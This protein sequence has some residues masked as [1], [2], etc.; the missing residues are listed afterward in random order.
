MRISYVAVVAVAL[1]LSV[2]P[3]V[4][5]SDDDGSAIISSA[6]HKAKTLGYTDA[7]TGVFH[8]VI[9]VAPEATTAPLTGTIQLTINVTI[10]STFTKG[11]ILLCS[12]MVT[13][14]SINMAS[15]TGTG[16]DWLEDAYSTQT[17]GGTSA[18]CA[19]SI[20]YSWGV[21]A[22]SSTVINELDGEY[23]VA[24][25]APGTTTTTLSGVTPL[26]SSTSS[27]VSTTKMPATGA[28][29]KFTVNATL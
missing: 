7:Q 19:V 26:R 10:K 2:V 3:A 8:P 20:P 25:M 1:G 9:R 16:T 13:A 14:T 29:T 6:S 22:A 17:L 4:A 18:T 12:S 11:S 28:T 15:T 27:F 21:P 23:T 24:V 5:Q